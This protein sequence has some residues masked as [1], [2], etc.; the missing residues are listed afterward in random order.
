MIGNNTDL[1]FNRWGANLIYS[2][3][4]LAP[5]P[6]YH[7]LPNENNVLTIPP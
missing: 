6:S 3:Y 1:K 2:L 5:S 4:F 7:S